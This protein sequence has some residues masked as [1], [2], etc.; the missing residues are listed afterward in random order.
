[1]ISPFQSITSPPICN[2]GNSREEGS[3]CCETLKED[4]LAKENVKI[5]TPIKKSIFE[6]L[7][8]PETLF[9][10]PEDNSTNIPLLPPE[11]RKPLRGGTYDP[12]IC[13]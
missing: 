8:F 3:T 5:S 4:L 2:N 7:S 13:T 10:C 1:M 9:K 12:T 6:A 11:K